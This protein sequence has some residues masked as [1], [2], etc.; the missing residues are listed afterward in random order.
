MYFLWPWDKKSST[1]FL[2]MQVNT[3]FLERTWI[4]V[5]YRTANTYRMFKLNCLGIKK[6]NQ[7]NYNAL[8]HI[9]LLGKYFK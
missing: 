4:L 9:V 5:E 1:P 7:E 6:I 3:N 2:G 8:Y